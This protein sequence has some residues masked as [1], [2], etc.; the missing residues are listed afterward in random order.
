MRRGGGGWEGESEIGQDG[1]ADE[2][3]SK[4]RGAQNGEGGKRMEKCGDFGEE[5]VME[6]EWEMS[7][8]LHPRKMAAFHIFNIPDKH[9]GHTWFAYKVHSC[10][11]HIFSSAVKAQKS[12]KSKLTCSF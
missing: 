11:K 4:S 9:S 6:A 8:M 2:E 5:G 12:I 7:E 1:A 3:W 10:N